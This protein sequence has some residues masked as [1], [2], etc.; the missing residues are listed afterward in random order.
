MKDLARSSARFMR[1]GDTRQTLI[2]EKTHDFPEDVDVDP[3][4]GAPRTPRGP[5]LPL[6]MTAKYAPS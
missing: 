4:A 2:N 1:H 5:L 6:R 3:V